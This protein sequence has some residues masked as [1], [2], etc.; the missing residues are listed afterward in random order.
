MRLLELLNQSPKFG[1][2]TGL[3]LDSALLDGKNTQS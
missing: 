2:Y 1:I 3:F